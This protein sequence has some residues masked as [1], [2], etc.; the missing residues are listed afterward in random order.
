MSADVRLNWGSGPQA[1]AGWI[2]ADVIEGQ[3]IEIVGDIRNGLPLDSESVDYIF[4]S[5]A[6][7]QLPFFDVRT[8]LHELRRVLKT[9]GVLRL[10]LP[11]LDRAIDALRR[12]D[13]DYFYVPDSDARTVSGKFVVQMTWYGSSPMLFNYENAREMLEDAQF[14]R[15]CRCS[16]KVTQSRFPEIV[17]LDNR[18]RETLFLE[19]EK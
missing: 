15:V 11:D 12:G 14:S 16:Y 18:E 2:N 10:G 4:S 1:V 7:Q 8:A 6:L 13:G 9:G 17:A 3:G 19:A 5:H